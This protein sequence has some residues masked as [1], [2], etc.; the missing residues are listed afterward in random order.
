MM[1]A[2]YSFST[3]QQKEKVKMKGIRH[4]RTRD[5]PPP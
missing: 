4:D 3:I 2:L 5:R 1:M